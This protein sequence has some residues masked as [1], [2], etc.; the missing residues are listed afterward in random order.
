MNILMKRF[1]TGYGGFYYPENLEPLNSES[2][3]YC[4]GAGEDISHDVEIAHKLG[5]NV[6]IF[7]PTPRAIQHVDYITKILNHEEELIHDKRY[8]GGDPTYLYQVMS[9]RI[10]PEKIKMFPYGLHTE[11]GDKKFYKPTNTEYVSHSAVPGMKSDAFIVVPMKTLQTIMKELDHDHID[12]LKIDIEG[13]ECDVIDQMLDLRIF[14]KYLAIDF[15]LGWT[16]EKIRDMDRC[17]ST[18]EKLTNHGYKIIHHENSDFSFMK[19][20]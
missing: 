19:V 18:V 20:N 16:G 9:H 2:V 14:P 7:D 8:G 4:V 13:S 1:G 6:Y 5:S 11:D 17:K 12:L 10:D 3:I 15:D